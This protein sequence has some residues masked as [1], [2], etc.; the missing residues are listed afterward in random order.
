MQINNNKLSKISINKDT[1]IKEDVVSENKSEQKTYDTLVQNTSSYVMPFLGKNKV[2]QKQSLAPLSQEERDVKNAI[3][4]LNNDYH[5]K[6]VEAGK[7]YWDYITNNT[8]ENQEKLDNAQNTLD[9]FY[10]D[11]KLYDKFKN[12]KEN[13]KIK[14]PELKQELDEVLETFKAYNSPEADEVDEDYAKVANI[15]KKVQ[16]KANKFENPEGVAYRDYISKDIVKLVKAR[17][18]YAKK[19]GYA[20]FYEMKM[21][22]QGKDSKQIDE[23][24]EKI[25]NATNEIEKNQKSISKETEKLISSRLG[26][27]NILGLC[28]DVYKNM[29]WDIMDMPIT[30]FDLFPRQNKINSRQTNSVD[31]NKDVR[32]LADL[33]LENKPLFSVSTL[34][35]ELGHAVHYS[36]FGKNLPN[37][38]KTI[39]SE[40]LDEGVALLMGGLMEKE[41]TIS[42]VLDLPE[43]AT[44]EIKDASLSSKAD[45]IRSYIQVDRFEKAMYENP[46]QDLQKLW[47]D[48]GEKYNN[49][50]YS[51]LEW[52]DIDHFIHSPVYYHY[53]AEG[54]V[55][56][57]QLYNAVSKNGTVKL[58]ESKDTAKF[59]NDKIFKYGASKTDE[60]ILKSA[61]GKALDVDAYCKQFKK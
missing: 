31:P 10:Q 52:T 59:F 33:D 41:G 48:C 13:T 60:E 42:K 21:A 25:T 20:N 32:V 50:N 49:K 35:H 23:M 44:K 3:N 29:G 14:N 53:Y 37:S 27:N 19:N 4:K 38:Q 17:N 58:T 16:L 34:M 12:L 18:T 28:S 54:E 1:P 15:E 39:A 46:D 56:A 11:E 6:E 26:K 9:T 36:S 22:E 45:K 61:T 8:Q 55:V 47:K 7:A 5:S 24:F 57:E 51:K 40:T 30:K 2:H 43:K